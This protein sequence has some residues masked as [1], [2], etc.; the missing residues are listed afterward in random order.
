TS[1]PSHPTRP[2]MKNFFDNIHKNNCD[3][4]VI[5]LR[6]NRGGNLED[7]DFLVGQFTA[8]PIL[9]GYARYKNGVGRLDF[10]PPLP[11]M[12]NPQAGATDF[13]KP[14]V[15]LADIYSAALC[16]TVI[17]AF[18]SLP[19]TKVTVIG[20]HTYGS[21]GMFAGNDISTLGGSFNMSSMA[22]ARLSNT[23]LMDKDRHF[24]FDG[25]SPD[26]EVK[27]SNAS[28]DRMLQTGVDIQLE[29]AI[30]FINQ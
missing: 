22:S 19:D 25:I 14:I 8:K 23:A 27:Y 11:L 15:I 28:I 7:A 29:K 30:Q 9:S 26:L 1:G 20:E 10:T 13:K 24:T 17:N 21:S 3:A 16:E 5:D 4:V 18:K 6:N 12:V 2:V